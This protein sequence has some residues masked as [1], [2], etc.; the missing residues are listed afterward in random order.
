MTVGL[1]YLKRPDTVGHRSGGGRM[2]TANL[3]IRV[4][5]DTPD[6]VKR[7]RETMERQVVHMVRLIDDLLDV[8]RITSGRIQLQRGPALLGAL[9]ESAVEANASAI[10]ARNIMLS[11]EVPDAP[12]VLDVDPTR[13]VQVV[14]NLLHN[15]TKFTPMGGTVALTARISPPDDTGLGTLRLSVRDSGIGIAET[16]LPRVFDLFS[17]ADRSASD[18]GLG[19]GLALA[20]RIVEM[21][22]GRIEVRSDGPGQ[23]S[24]F[25]INFP[26][27]SGAPAAR[28]K[29]TAA[30]PRLDCRVIVI[31]DNRDAA[32]VTAMLI[33]ELGGE[34]HVAFD[35]E[36]GLRVLREFPFDA[37]LL[38]VGMAGMDGYET[39]RR[40]R[41]EFGDV[42]RVV[43]LTGFGQD[44]DKE[45][46]A[47]AGFNGH[48]TKPADPAAVI[49][50]LRRV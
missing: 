15:A 20:Q 43:A 2:T 12:C 45:R 35:A 26:V 9:I 49:A 24:E 50:A 10:A 17:Q 27:S 41:Q 40:I 36:N 8:S 3:L 25:I 32:T 42:V 46:A 19:I 16:F 6:A 33:E 34:C 48:L 31:D 37:V 28:S 21:H 18:T 1:Y 7:I 13:F 5:G 38:D 14:S 4:A 30:D 23:G 29:P 47:R 22:G 39:C 44:G 11:V